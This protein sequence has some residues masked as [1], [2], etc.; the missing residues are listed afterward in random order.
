MAT[1]KRHE[2]IEDDLDQMVD[3]ELRAAGDPLA[4]YEEFAGD[5]DANPDDRRRDPL[6]H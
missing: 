1:K 3:D 6:R 5:D 4:D 2:T